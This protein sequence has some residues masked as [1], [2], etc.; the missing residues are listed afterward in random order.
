MNIAEHATMRHHFRVGVFS[1]EMSKDQLTD[2]LISSVARVDSRSLRSGYI[3]ET[4]ELPR[5][6]DA[7]GQLNEVSLFIEDT[8]GITVTQARTI[9]QR[10]QMEVGLDL[11]I[12]DYL[13]LMAAGKMAKDAGRVEEVSIIARG[14]KHSCPGTPR[15][16]ILRSRAYRTCASRAHWNRT[17]TS[18]SSYGG[19]N[20][21]RTTIRT[22]KARS[23]K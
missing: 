22:P 16:G 19:R 7:M 20:P 9:A 1:L 6:L 11:V 12:V 18:S 10:M 2:R 4:E 15:A 8:P 5:I 21:G 23:S 3:S 13:Q 17:R 14:L